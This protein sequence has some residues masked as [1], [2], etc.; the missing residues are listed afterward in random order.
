VAAAVALADGGGLQA[1][2]MRNLA[3]ELGYEVMS[4][5]NHVANKD[6]LLT[7]MVDRVAD[8]IAEPADAVLQPAGVKS[9]AMIRAV[10][11][12]ARMALVAHPWAAPLWQRV[13]P[14]PA[15]LHFMEV[16]LRLFDQAGLPGDVAHYGF[17]AVTNHI[18][19]YTLQEQEMMSN[20]DQSD[21]L[22]KLAR[23]FLAGVD[24]DRFPYTVAHVEQ[25]LAGDTGS[26]FELVLD[27]ILDGLARLD[28]TG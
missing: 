2:S 13:M 5:Y 3:R 4:L 8:E 1:L 22:D 20:F 27:L 25:H 9:M 15:R 23:E 10:A 12:S 24:V 21:D 26:S 17:H 6:E 28:A 7:L 11:V 16:L 18:V 14:G 19:G